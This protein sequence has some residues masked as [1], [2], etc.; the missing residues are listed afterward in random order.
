MPASI[1][2]TQ[3]HVATT[4]K[5]ED[6]RTCEV[7][8]DRRPIVLLRACSVRGFPPVSSRRREDRRREG[9]QVRRV[10]RRAD[11]GGRA[12][13]D[14]P[15][16]RGDGRD[17]RREPGARSP[18]PPTSGSARDRPGRRGLGLERPAAQGQGADRGRVRAPARGA[19]ALH[20]PP[21]RGRRAADAG[22]R[23]LGRDGGRLRDGRDRARRAAAA[24]ADVRGRRPA[25]DAGRR[26]LPREAVRRPRAP[27]RRR[28][29][30]RAGAGR[31]HRR[32][33]RRLQRRD[34]GARARRPGD[35]PRAL[36]RPDAAPRGDPVR[37]RD[38][39]DV[40]EPRDRRLGRGRRPR[41]RRRADPGRA[42]AE[43]RDARDDRAD[44][45]RARSS[46]T[47]RSTRAA[48]SRPRTRRRTPTR[49]SSS[50]A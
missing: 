24:R 36:D 8:M 31:D 47:S 17:R 10:P 19:D 4:T 43:A 49:C 38:A 15:R 16:P 37:P 39:A 46:S 44:E 41:D 42:R 48:A 20:L 50:T 6:W 45:R 22:A 25:L 2:M 1:A 12:R 27:A 13:A 18:T 35:D 9:D 40:V 3:S 14:Q 26:V 7:G 32:R 30:R 33:D 28:A 5:V 21:H 11:A 34:H 23:R 29:R